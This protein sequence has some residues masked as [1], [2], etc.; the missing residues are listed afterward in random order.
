M[1]SCR[2]GTVGA[3]SLTRR[4]EVTFE[5]C[6]PKSSRVVRNGVPPLSEF[7]CVCNAYEIRW[8]RVLHVL[9]MDGGAFSYVKK[10]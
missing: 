8:Y 2:E 10:L 3:S 6:V 7:E 5:R 9:M 4:A 1:R